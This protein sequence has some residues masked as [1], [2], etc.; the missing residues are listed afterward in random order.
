M[1]SFKLFNGVFNIVE[2][3]LEVKVG[4]RTILDS[5]NLSL[6]RGEKHVLFGPNGSGKTSLIMAILGHPRYKIVNGEIWFNG[7]LINDLS[8]DE[9]VRLGLGIAFQ[10][11]PAVRGVKL[12]HLILKL[13]GT[14]MRDVVKTASFVGI[15]E[16][17]LNRDL[18]TGFSG[19]E[20]K[21][22]EILQLIAQ[23]PEL[24][25]LD[26]PDS[27]VDVENLELIGKILRSY[28]H[29]R[30][31]MIITHM[32]YILRYVKAEKAHVM[33]DGKIVCSGD[34]STILD[35]ILKDGYEWCKR[36][37]GVRKWEKLRKKL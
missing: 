22:S 13:L 15:D 25:L 18:N 10:S 5:L 19:G 12:K 20:A 27:G 1:L 3:I 17:L 26:E 33:L 30:S 34:A 8:I 21:K 36:C 35:T 28:F 24:L 9:R 32:G 7:H 4:E 29:D 16:L 11:P 14:D 37:R 6:G 31:M 2:N 23:D